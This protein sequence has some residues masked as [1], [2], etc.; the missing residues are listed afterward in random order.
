MGRR[1][2]GRKSYKRDKNT[3][4]KAFAYYRMPSDGLALAPARRYLPTHTCAIGS[5]APA[6]LY[7]R[8]YF[9]LSEHADAASCAAGVFYCA[10]SVLFLALYLLIATNF[11]FSVFWFYL[12]SQADGGF[13]VW[14]FFLVYSQARTEWATKESLWGK[15]FLFRRATWSG[16]PYRRIN[17]LLFYSSIT[18]SYVSGCR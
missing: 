17:W 16:P 9:T 7:V 14:A 18:F 1:T 15:N 12:F 2:V 13:F 8:R 11:L 3:R 6:R 5:R 4:P 10:Y